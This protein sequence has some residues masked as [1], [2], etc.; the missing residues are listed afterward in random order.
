MAKRVFLIILDSFGIGEEPDA[1]LFGDVGSHTLRSCFASNKFNCPNMRKIGLFNIDGVADAL[2][3]GNTAFAKSL[4][5][6][7]PIGQYARMRELSAGKDTIIGHWEL[8]GLVSPRPMPTFPDGFP[9]SFIRQFEKAVGR[10]CIVNKP[11]SGTDVI[12]D[13]GEYAM[14]NGDLIVYTSADS[15]FQIAANEAVIPIEELYRDCEIARKMLQG[16]LAVG[17][18]IAR[19]FVGTD[20]S[21]FKRTSRRHDYALSPFGP[22][23]LDRIRK[24]GKTVYGIGKINDIF[25]GQ[26]IS[27][28][29]RTS[30]NTDGMNKTMEYAAIDFEGLCFVNLVDFDSLYGHRRNPDGYAEALSEFDFWL[31]GFMKK[32][33]EDDV[34]MISADHGCDPCFTAHTDHTREYVPLLMYGPQLIPGVDHGTVQGFTFCAD[35]VCELLGV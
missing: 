24:A 13:Y 29:V 28:F 19:P 2:A 7:A 16:D 3:R 20:A 5:E 11:Y 25:N 1:A 4:P 10:R 23:V 31:T 6:E 34:L 9:E 33:R 17:R 27:D 8:A 32:M 15:V 18:V 35:A 30:G 21:N 22:T 26:G 14:R 12:R